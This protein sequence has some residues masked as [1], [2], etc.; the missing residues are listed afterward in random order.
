MKSKRFCLTAVLA[1][2]FLSP[3][4]RAAEVEASSFELSGT[5]G[6]VSDYTSRGIAQSDEKLAVQAGVLVNHK[7][8]LYAG[9]WTSSVDFNDGNEAKAE[10]DLYGGF[11]DKYQNILYDVGLIYSI[12]LG[13]SG[14]LNYDYVEGLALLGYDFDK[15][16]TS[17]SLNYSPEFFGKSGDAFYTHAGIDVPLPKG[18]SLNAGAGYQSV[19]DNSAF[20][21]EDYADWSFGLSY[22]HANLNLYAT[23]MDT[24]LDEPNE[25]FDGCSAGVVFGATINF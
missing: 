25:C 14:S 1:T 2:C 13:A 17:I 19:E 3:I 15:F 11:S 12:Y 10:F 20:G 21:Y 5:L 9:A 4:T 18:F 24:D 6:I 22:V 16:T 7:S 23:Y 8:G